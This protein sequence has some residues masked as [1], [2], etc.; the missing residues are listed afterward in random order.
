MGTRRERYKRRRA[1]MRENR[2]KGSSWWGGGG[3]KGGG[4]FNV[5]GSLAKTVADCEL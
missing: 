1:G 2:I 3:R 4:W 5:G